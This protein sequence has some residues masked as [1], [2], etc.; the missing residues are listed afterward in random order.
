M[1][2]HAHR[3]DG[4]YPRALGDQPADRLLLGN[5]AVWALTDGRTPGRFRDLSNMLVKPDR[6]RMSRG[7][8]RRSDRR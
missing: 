6:P 8:W 3:I 5:L 4:V 7:W 1:T 2:A